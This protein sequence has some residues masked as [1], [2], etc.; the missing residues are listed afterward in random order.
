MHQNH[1]KEKLYRIIL[2]TSFSLS[3]VSIVGNAI[4]SFPI[5]LSIKWMLLALLSLFFYKTGNNQLLGIKSSLWFFLFL[6][7]IFLPYAFLE[8][9]G[10]K[11][12][13]LGYIFVYLI[14]MTYLF[15]G[16]DRTLLIISTIFIFIILHC[17]EYFYPNLVTSHSDQ[18]QFIDRIIQMPL[19][20][21]ASFLIIKSFSNAYNEVNNQL[22]IY[23]H[24]DELTSLYNR[25]YFNKILEDI[26]SRKSHSTLILIDLDNFKKI[27]DCHGHLIGDQ[28]LKYLAKLLKE[29]FDMNKDIISRWGGDEFAIVST[30]DRQD[31]VKAIKEIHDSFYLYASKYE[32]TAGISYGIVLLE[33]YSD[34]DSAFRDVDNLLYDFKN[35]RKSRY[36]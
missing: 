18:S 10:S 16:K 20:L 21:F 1:I 28:S 7:F 25:R 34:T 31:A 13:A 11:N 35:K 36:D 22:Y 30:L 26:I 33:L 19:L 6:I 15:K 12:N 23:A 4:S 27:N 2:I 17:I 8:S 5:Y 3:A 14:S 24:Y 9:G 32:K 29:K